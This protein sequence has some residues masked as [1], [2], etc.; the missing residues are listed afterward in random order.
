MAE[1]HYNWDTNMFSKLFKDMT[2]TAADFLEVWE[3]NTGISFGGFAC[4]D[5]LT[6]IER[7]PSGTSSRK[8]VSTSNNSQAKKKKQLDEIDAAIE[9][10]KYGT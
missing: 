7:V 8:R 1:E 9:K 4:I 5:P 2:T 10:K 3:E 6:D